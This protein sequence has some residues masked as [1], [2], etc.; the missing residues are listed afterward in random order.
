MYVFIV[1]SKFPRTSFLSIQHHQPKGLF[2]FAWTTEDCRRK[3]CFSMGLSTSEDLRS[4]QSMVIH[5][6]WQHPSA[7]KK[8]LQKGGRIH[9]EDLVLFFVWEKMLK[10]ILECKKRW[11]KPFNSERYQACG[12]GN[13]VSP[14]RAFLFFS[15][16]RRCNR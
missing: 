2:F 11:W 6:T 8:I 9:L 13:F 12:I 14:F 4:N 3:G 16:N 5:R 15:T 10:K 1:V 7:R